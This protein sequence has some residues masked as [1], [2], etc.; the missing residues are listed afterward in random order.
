M[1]IV[2]REPGKSHFWGADQGDTPVELYNEFIVLGSDGLLPMPASR[3][4]IP[5]YVP[6]PEH[7]A[8]PLTMCP[9]EPFEGD[10]RKERGAPLLTGR[11]LRT[12]VLEAEM[13]PQKRAYLTTPALGY[14]I[15]ESSAAGAARQPGPTPEVD[16]WDEIRT[17]EFEERDAIADIAE[18]GDNSLGHYKRTVKAEEWKSRE[19]GWKLA[20]AVARAYWLF[21]VDPAQVKSRA[22]KIGHL[23]SLETEIRQFWGLEATTDDF[24]KAILKDRQN[25]YDK[26]DIKRRFKVV[27]E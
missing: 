3:P 19:S 18:I 2:Y 22:L 16:T 13:P 17:E 4:T 10:E 26:L 8:S 25:H 23:L 24:I 15:G 21:I 5:D 11:T 12:D 1:S 20:I 7:P 9:E 6:G 27:L 14:E